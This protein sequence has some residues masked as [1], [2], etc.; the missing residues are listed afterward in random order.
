MK[1]RKEKLGLDSIKPWDLIADEN[2]LPPVKPF[3]TGAE[4]E[5][6]VHAALAKVDAEIGEY[7]GIMRKDRLLDLESREGKAPGG[8][9]ADLPARRLPFIFMNAV[10]RTRDVQTLLHEAGHAA[11]LFLARDLEPS[12]YLNPPLEFAE[13]ASMS[14]ELISLPFADLL[15]DAKDVERVKKAQL[16]EILTFLPFMAMIDSFQRWVYLNPS[17]AKTRADYW[18]SL[19][20]KFRPH[21]DWTGVEDV[22][23]FG[24]QYLHVFKVAFYYIEYG[25]AQLG[26][27][28]VGTNSLSDYGKAVALYKAGLSL[29]GSKPLPQLFAAAGAKFDMT[30]KTLAPL[31]AALVKE[32]GL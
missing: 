19:E 28:Q 24:W 17:D 32:I 18:E 29:G 16:A 6:K 27:L 25:I 26:A 1:I 13:V 12:A 10:G 8:Y 7:F 22:K 23:R 4:L 15:Y 5:E 21:I 3:E 11:N 30:E 31:T 2:G 20:N 9:M 14:M